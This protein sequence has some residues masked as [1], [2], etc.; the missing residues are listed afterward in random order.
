MKYFRYRGKR[1]LHF[2]YYFYF[3]TYLKS[4]IRPL[5]LKIKEK[6]LFRA[7]PIGLND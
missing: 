5:K 1:G 6:K 3:G 7:S 4:S 2:N